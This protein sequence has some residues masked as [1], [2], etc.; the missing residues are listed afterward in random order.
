V[1][2]RAR[3][4]VQVAFAF[5]LTPVVRRGVRTR[6]AAPSSKR[7]ST[8]ARFQGRRSPSA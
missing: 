3:R 8:S 4:E 7:C 1:R 2:I 6:P 5:P